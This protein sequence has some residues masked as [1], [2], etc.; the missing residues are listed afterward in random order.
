MLSLFASFPFSADCVSFPVFSPCWKEAARTA[1]IAERQTMP[2]EDAVLC[3]NVGTLHSLV[4][5]PHTMPSCPPVTCSTL[6]VCMQI[7]VHTTF[8]SLSGYPSEDCL[9]LFSFFLLSYFAR[10]F[11]AADVTYFPS[12][13]FDSYILLTFTVATVDNCGDN[14]EWIY[15]A[16]IKTTKKSKVILC[17]RN[18]LMKLFARGWKGNTLWKP[19]PAARQWPWG[20][21]CGLVAA[22]VTSNLFLPLHN[23]CRMVSI[24][25]QGVD[26][27]DRC[28]LLFML[29]VTSVSFVSLVQFCSLFSSPFL[30]VSKK[31]NWICKLLQIGIRMPVNGSD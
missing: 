31:W 24:A 6:G 15:L 27:A 22:Y 2:L 20:H 26:L 16:S 14:S 7:C 28:L 12:D 11:S 13:R 1:S 10:P 9:L 21:H 25:E 3:R 5:Q 29:C 4:A 30:I 8:I 18:P 23:E 17:K 19:S